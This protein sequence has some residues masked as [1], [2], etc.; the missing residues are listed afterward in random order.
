VEKVF[1]QNFLAIGLTQAREILS[2]PWRP[3]NSFFLVVGNPASPL[4][5]AVFTLLRQL[6]LD[7][8][9]SHAELAIPFGVILRKVWAGCRTWAWRG[10]RWY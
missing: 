1:S 4:N 8:T 5:L 9:N 10:R 2:R 7:A 3:P 6:G